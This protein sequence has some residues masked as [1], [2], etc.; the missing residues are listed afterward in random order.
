MGHSD[1]VKNFI[2]DRWV[3]NES[4]EQ[5]SAALWSQMNYKMSRSAVLGLVDRSRDAGDKRA[6]KKERPARTAPLPTRQ[7]APKKAKKPA[8]PKALINPDDYE[9]VDFMDLRENH[10]RWPY[11][12]E[13]D[14]RPAVAYCGASKCSG[15]SYCSF[16]AQ[17]AYRPLDVR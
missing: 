1:K 10:C 2:L 17:I 13:R 8:E 3:G 15:G 6:V 14:G 9:R 5:I 4:A 7:R 11:D 16:H 12:V